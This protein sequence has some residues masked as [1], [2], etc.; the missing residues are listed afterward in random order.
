MIEKDFYFNEVFMQS[1][2]E[3]QAL[4]N[5]LNDNVSDDGLI[6]LSRTK[7]AK[8]LGKS[9]TLMANYISRINT[10]DEC[11]KQIKPGVY[12]LKYTNLKE[13]GVFPVILKALKKIDKNMSN[14]I[15]LSYKQKA[16]YLDIS[17]SLI[18]IIEGY[19]YAELRKYK[20]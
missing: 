2:N 13:F 3:H 18:P 6:Y 1:L 17:V 12:K 19:L 4:I 14:Y 16:D 7:M 5:Y 10:I 11:V 15:S 20:K 8:K 9:P